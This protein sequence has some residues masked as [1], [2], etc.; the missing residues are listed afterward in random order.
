MKT[1]TKTLE[2]IA[3]AVKQDMNERIDQWI[4][5]FAEETGDLSNF[6]SISQLESDIIH[7]DN[8]TRK[9]FLDMISDCLSN[10]DEK[11]MISSKK[12]HSE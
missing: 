1:D 8:E 6:P 5:K 2:E 12:A 11:E 4:R 10:I 3:N 9:I 7:L